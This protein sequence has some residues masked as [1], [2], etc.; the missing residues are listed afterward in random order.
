MTDPAE[1][2]PDLERA[3]SERPAGVRL[4]EMSVVVE[5]GRAHV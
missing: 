1:V 5:I 2:F 3:Q 4:L